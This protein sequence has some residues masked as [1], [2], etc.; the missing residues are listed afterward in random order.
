MVIVNCRL[1]TPGPANLSAANSRKR[2][3]SPDALLRCVRFAKTESNFFSVPDISNR[4][5][6]QIG[7]TRT[8][9]FNGGAG[10]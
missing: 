6:H 4:G 5:P 8:L 1:G 9:P 10:S 2:T 3:V 7:P